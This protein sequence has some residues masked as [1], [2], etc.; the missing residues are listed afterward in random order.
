MASLAGHAKQPEVQRCSSSDGGDGGDGT[1]AATP[2]D[3]PQ[4]YT[5]SPNPLIRV[6]S[7]DRLEGYPTHPTDPPTLRSS[8]PPLLYGATHPPL[9][10]SLTARLLHERNSPARTLI[11]NTPD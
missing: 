7:H 10:R 3:R 6:D 2:D 5:G 1:A 9:T 4:L 11:R 8:I